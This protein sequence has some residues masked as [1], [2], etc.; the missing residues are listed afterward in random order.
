MDSWRQID[1]F[2]VEGEGESEWR[3]PRGTSDW[4][5]RRFRNDVP[6]GTLLPPLIP[7][8]LARLAGVDYDSFPRKK[9]ALDLPNAFVGKKVKPS[10]KEVATALGPAS[11]AWSELI[12]WLTGLGITCK[13]WQS[14]SPKYGWALRPKVKT[15]TILYLAPSEGCF[16]ASFVLGDKAVAA[17]NASGLPQSVLQEIAG[18]RR[19]AEGTGV[20]LI[21]RD[22]RDLDPIRA[23]VAIKLAN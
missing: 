5:K 21:V 4:L 1:A 11:T 10:S 19:Y 18:A 23:L 8:Q 16:R 12:A 14:I 20:R 3:V 9:V 15:R 22:S 17:A 13:D 2:R 6:R 7:L